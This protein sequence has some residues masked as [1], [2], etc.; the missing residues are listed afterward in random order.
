MEVDPFGVDHWPFYS[1]PEVST[2]DPRNGPKH[3]A[4][5][6][7]WRESPPVQWINGHFSIRTIFRRKK[8]LKTARVFWVSGCNPRIHHRSTAQE[9]CRNS[10][11]ATE[12]R[13]DQTGVID[14]WRIIH[15]VIRKWQT[16]SHLCGMTLVWNPPKTMEVD[17]K[18]HR[19]RGKCCQPLVPNG[20]C[21]ASQGLP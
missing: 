18:I 19:T 17:G 6:E 5:S 12:M 20:G 15:K 16:L 8:R 1:C 11:P 14:G 7:I 13:P 3:V 21:Q 4:F 9:L 2:W 10:W